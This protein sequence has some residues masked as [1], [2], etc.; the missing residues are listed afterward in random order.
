MANREIINLL[1]RELQILIFPNLWRNIF[2]PKPWRGL[3][4]PNTGRIYFPTPVTSSTCMHIKFINL[5]LHSIFICFQNSLLGEQISSPAARLCCRGLEEN[6]A[7][8]PRRRG[9]IF[10]RRSWNYVLFRQLWE[11]GTSLE[12]WKL[13][14]AAS[15]EMNVWWRA[16]F[17]VNAK[18]GSDPGSSMGTLYCHVSCFLIHIFEWQHISATYLCTRLS[19]CRE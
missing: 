1:H 2:L 7:L 15:L 12:R 4:R 6:C 18:V 5:W 13:F 14:C 8:F 3:W 10:P 17:Y 16:M 9:E 19:D 11:K